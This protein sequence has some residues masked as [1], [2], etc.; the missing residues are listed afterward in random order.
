ML[1]HNLTRINNIISGQHQKK[2]YSQPAYSE[3]HINISS[4]L[5]H[6]ENRLSTIIIL[7]TCTIYVVAS[8]NSGWFDLETRLWATSQED[9]VSSCTRVVS[10]S[11]GKFLHEQQEFRT[12]N[13][14]FSSIIWVSLSLINSFQ[15]HSQ[16]PTGK[17]KAT[18]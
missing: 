16:T 14:F 3:S 5:T 8:L 6:S 13:S 2:V 7:L 17:H 18:W 1:C 15:R 4:R 10:L 12:S 11:I 9:I